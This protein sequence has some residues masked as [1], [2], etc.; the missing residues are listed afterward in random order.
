MSPSNIE[1]IPPLPK[2]IDTGIILCESLFVRIIEKLTRTSQPRVDPEAER[3][4]EKAKEVIE[5]TSHKRNVFDTPTIVEAVTKFLLT[6]N[7]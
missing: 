7:F 6:G 1:K 5:M 3:Q 2:G 4:F